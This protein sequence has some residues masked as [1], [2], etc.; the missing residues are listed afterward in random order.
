M[1]WTFSMLLTVLWLMGVVTGY[2]LGGLIHVLPV[3]AVVS[4]VLG[5]LRRQRHH[6]EPHLGSSASR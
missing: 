6:R 2:T 4:A 1:F 3:F 5:G